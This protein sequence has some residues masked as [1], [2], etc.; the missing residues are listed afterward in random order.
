MNKKDLANIIGELIG[1]A[2]I[3]QRIAL[4]AFIQKIA[5]NLS[6]NQT[7]KIQEIGIFHL[8]KIGEHEKKTNTGSTKP[9]YQVLCFP[10]N[11]IKG[12]DDFISFNVTSQLIKNSGSVD[13]AF[14]IS[15]GKPLILLTDENANEFL[16]QSSFLL[17]NKDIEDKLDEII[18]NGTFLKN[19]RIDDKF[20]IPEED[21]LESDSDSEEEVLK[22]EPEEKSSNLP[23]NFGI[24]P[25]QED[26]IKK[27][28]PK[29]LIIEN[30]TDSIFP[31]RNFKKDIST[32]GIQMSG[33]DFPIHEQRTEIQPGYSN[34]LSDNE[35][36]N[37]KVNFNFPDENLITAVKEGNQSK[38]TK[39][40]NLLWISIVAIIVVIAAGTYYVFIYRVNEQIKYSKIPIVM[41][42][43][44]GVIKDT[45]MKIDSTGVLKNI[46]AVNTNPDLSNKIIKDDNKNRMIKEYLYSDGNRYTLQISSWKTRSVAEKEVEK[47]RHAGYDAYIMIKNPNSTSPFYCIRI[48]DFASLN[49]AEQFYK[50]LK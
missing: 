42:N 39:R 37:K 15:L 41:K 31:N 26:E 29:D 18:T 24:V 3:E 33:E 13:N 17:H 9:L 22:E 35:E 23:W 4:D 47:F 44:P 7:I 1:V 14:S 40:K 21:I 19:F 45:L 25:D 32:S 50:K 28:V 49:E 16:S 27:D 2:K 10:L 46:S 8:R 43:S 34:S 38:K 12:K 36:V 5:D 30:S 11:N 20:V 48:G 6:V